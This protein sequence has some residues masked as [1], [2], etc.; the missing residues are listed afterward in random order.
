MRR[1]EMKRVLLA[2]ATGYLDKYVGRE[3]KKQRYHTKELVRNNNKL[4]EHGTFQEPVIRKYVD[5]IAIGDITKPNTIKNV[6]E[7]IE[8]VF[9]SVGITNRQR[10]ITF[11]DVDL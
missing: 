3:L 10:G 5:E 4:D 8:Y 2:G 9:T 6:C 11:K 1:D 7:N